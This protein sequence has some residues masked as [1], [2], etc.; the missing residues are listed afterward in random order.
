M[1]TFKVYTDISGQ[2]KRKYYMLI[3]YF[4]DI[5]F[6]MIEWV[7]L[8]KTGPA[9]R[10]AYLKAME[11]YEIT[12]GGAD[13]V[14][15]LEILDNNA[16]KELLRKR[17]VIFQL[18]APNNHRRNAAKREMRK[19]QNQ[20]ICTFRGADVLHYRSYVTYATDIDRERVTDTVA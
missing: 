13:N 11:R 7:G 16:N 3:L 8:S 15:N 14:P 18:V 10:T 2:F 1:K 9:Y 19:A 20:C 6:V 5:N 17:A 12:K 4:Y